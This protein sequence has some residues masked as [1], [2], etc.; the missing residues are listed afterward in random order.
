MIHSQHSRFLILGRYFLEDLDRF[1][2]GV[3]VSR[4]GRTRRMLSRRRSL[5]FEL[6]AG[7]LRKHVSCDHAPFAAGEYMLQV[8]RLSMLLLLGHHLHLFGGGLLLGHYILNNF[9]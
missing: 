2:L 6:M 3:F 8:S 9:W 5:E 4:C 7:S 1:R